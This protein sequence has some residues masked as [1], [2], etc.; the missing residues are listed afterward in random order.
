MKSIRF[1]VCNCLQCEDIVLIKVK[2][3]E[4]QNDCC[5]DFKNLKILKEF[6]D[7]DEAKNY[8]K[9]YQKDEEEEL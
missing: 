2:F 3:V 7:E 6:N 1:Y 8:M 5:L 9:L 4:F